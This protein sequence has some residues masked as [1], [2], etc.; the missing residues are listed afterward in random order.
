MK[1][2]RLIVVMVAFV[3]AAVPVPM[4]QDSS[5]HLKLYVEHSDQDRLSVIDVATNTIIKEI[6][7]GSRPHGLAVDASQTRLYVST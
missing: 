6:K 2:L 1:H 7:V 4:A 3:L 5:R